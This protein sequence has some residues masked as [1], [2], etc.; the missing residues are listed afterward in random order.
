MAAA[1]RF[2]LQ[3]PPRPPDPP[4]WSQGKQRAVACIRAYLGWADTLILTNQR[5]VTQAESVINQITRI[6]TTSAEVR[7]ALDQAWTHATTVITIIG[8]L[9]LG[10]ITSRATIQTLI[11]E[12]SEADERGAQST[13]GTARQAHL[14]MQRTRGPVNTALSQV[15]HFVKEA[16]A[17][18]EK[19]VGDAEKVV[20]DNDTK[21]VVRWV[22]GIVAFVALACF[23]GLLIYRQRVDL[24]TPDKNRLVPFIGL[25]G[26]FF[27]VSS[28][29]CYL[30]RPREQPQARE[31]LRLTRE[32]LHLIKEI[33]IW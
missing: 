28:V 5:R 23:I 26:T 3:G 6:I 15:Q 11:T 4:D 18:A 27:A 33:K 2:R 25:T 21:N 1:P 29:A 19:V 20:G 24:L 16:T 8:E 32:T 10:D 31:T 17:A 9:A 22:V 30:L 7:T 12:A 14:A 13:E